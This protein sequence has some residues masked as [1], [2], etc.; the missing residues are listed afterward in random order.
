MGCARPAFLF[1]LYV[2]LNHSL[3]QLFQHTYN[4]IVII[5]LGRKGLCDASFSWIWPAAP[6]SDTHSMNL[7]ST[8][9]HCLDPFRLTIEKSIM[10]VIN[11]DFNSSDPP[12]YSP[13]WLGI[14]INT[15]MSLVNCRLRNYLCAFQTKM[16]ASTRSKP[17]PLYF[18]HWV[19][20]FLT[21]AR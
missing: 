1:G 21:S 3:V 15:K 14:L 4:Q 18:A 6:Q 17:N 2:G 7:V 10:I 8:V 16:K 12:V 11:T 20:G 9:I 13:T 5:W 19:Y